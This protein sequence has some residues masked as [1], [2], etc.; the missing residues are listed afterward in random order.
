MYRADLPPTKGPLLRGKTRW[1]GIATEHG[2]TARPC[3]PRGFHRRSEPAAREDTRIGDA[4]P[5][6]PFRVIPYAS[7]RRP[8]C[9]EEVWWWS[10]SRIAS[11][12]VVGFDGH[13]LPGGDSCDADCVVITQ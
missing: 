1:V 4:D 12:A 11:K 10:A 7:N 9:E 3:S 13:G 5:N 6:G 8:D 2:S